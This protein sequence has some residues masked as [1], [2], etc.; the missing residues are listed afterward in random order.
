MQ[1]GSASSVRPC[2]ARQLSE[3][4]QPSYKMVDSYSTL[5]NG[6]AIFYFEKWRQFSADDQYDGRLPAAVG[7]IAGFVRV[8]SR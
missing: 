7:C 1:R 8:G 3:T 6:K 5:K 2:H 4:K